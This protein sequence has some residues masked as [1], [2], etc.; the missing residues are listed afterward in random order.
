MIKVEVRPQ[1]LSHS[2]FLKYFFIK[3]FQILLTTRFY[4]MKKLL[5]LN[6]ALFLLNV[7]NGCSS[8]SENRTIS[9]NAELDSIAPKLAVIPTFENYLL[10]YN[11]LEFDSLPIFYSS[12]EGDDSF[13]GTKIDSLYFKFLPKSITQTFVSDPEIY[14]CNKFLIDSQYIG[15]LTRVIPN[16]TES[17]IWLLIYDVKEKN[18]TD[19]WILAEK[20]GDDGMFT[21]K[22]S[23]LYENKINGVEFFTL[24]QDC[25]FSSEPGEESSDCTDSVEAHKLKD[26]KFYILEIDTLSKHQILNKLVSAKQ[27]LVAEVN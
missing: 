14:A 23:W 16:Y 10:S 7:I 8:S 27:K 3:P 2:I 4:I 19:T 6:L 20:S 25:S 9:S 13:N 17:S 24:I 12:T 5:Y 21:F 15:L 18:F 1:L 11:N 22:S 26:G